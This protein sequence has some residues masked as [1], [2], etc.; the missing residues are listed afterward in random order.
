[1]SFLAPVLY[2]FDPCVFHVSSAPSLNCSLPVSFVI[3]HVTVPACVMGQALP[4][5]LPARVAFDRFLHAAFV[6]DL[7]LQ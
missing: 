6:T 3:C 5:L 2:V 4:E 7:C 1:M